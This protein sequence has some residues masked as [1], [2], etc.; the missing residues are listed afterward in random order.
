MGEP[1]FTKRAVRTYWDRMK[2]LAEMGKYTEAQKDRIIAEA[3]RLVD[4]FGWK[5]HPRGT[6]GL[7]DA[8]NPSPLP[9]DAEIDERLRDIG[10]HGDE[11]AASAYRTGHKD[12]LRLEAPIAEPVRGDAPESCTMNEWSM[13]EL[14]FWE[15]VKRIKAARGLLAGVMEGR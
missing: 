9:T 7:V 5:D 3:Q 11:S 6:K 13:Y 2:R 12:A 15:A 8:L 4:Q 10:L 14:G 1:V